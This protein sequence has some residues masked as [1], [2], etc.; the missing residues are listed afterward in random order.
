VDSPHVLVVGSSGILRPAAAALAAD[1][2]H[3]IG[4]SRTGGDGSLPVDARDLGALVA[5]LDGQS[6][7]QALIYRPAVSEESLAFLRAATSGRCVVVLTSDEADPAY[8]D[9]AIPADTLQLGWHTGDVGR[10]HSAAEISDAA[11]AV[12]AD[13]A[14]RILGTI[15]PWSSRP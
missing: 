10:W 7:S 1:G 4:V 9:A 11:L 15:R 6:W 14:P 12:L 5:A 3:V 8:G 13:G 2:A